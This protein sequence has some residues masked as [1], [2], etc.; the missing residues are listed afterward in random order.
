VA[1]LESIET[2]TAATRLI[3]VSPRGASFFGVK[4]LPR[5][6]GGITILK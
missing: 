3:F 2:Q 1:N 5:V 4:H 6:A